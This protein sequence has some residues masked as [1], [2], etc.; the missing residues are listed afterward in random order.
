MKRPNCP[1]HGDDVLGLAR[2]LLVGADI[3]RVEVILAECPH[4]ADF[5][6]EVFS[7]EAF[8]KVDGAVAEVFS[9]VVLPRRRRRRVWLAA[10]AAVVVMLAGTSLW[11]V[12]EEASSVL[13]NQV[14]AISSFDFEN[15]TFEEGGDVPDV[16]TEDP[17]AAISGRADEDDGSS[18][19]SSGLED[20]E[21][22]GWTL[23][24]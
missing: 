21:L 10:A 3:E 15:G 7:G 22:R 13:E 23:H 9:D 2:G 17:T 11:R 14:V 19:F 20:G 24:S 5:W 18:V 12:S 16:R 1:Q 4:C 8:D 6:A